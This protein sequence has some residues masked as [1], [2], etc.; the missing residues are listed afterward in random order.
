MKR[1][2]TNAQLKVLSKYIEDTGSSTSWSI[3]WG[4]M[5]V[6]ISG[7]K[8]NNQAAWDTAFTY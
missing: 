7:N 1:T 6:S 3:G 5:S 4:P 2:N 8:S